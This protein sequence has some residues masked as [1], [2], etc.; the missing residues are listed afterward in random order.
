LVGADPVSSCEQ[1]AMQMPPVS[2]RRVVRCKSASAADVQFHSRW[3]LRNCRHERVPV[4]SCSE[5]TASKWSHKLAALRL[6]SEGDAGELMCKRH[7]RKSCSV[8]P[9]CTSSAPLSSFHT[10][11]HCIACCSCSPFDRR[12]GNCPAFT[13]PVGGTVAVRRALSLDSW[14]AVCHSQQLSVEG[15]DSICA[16]GEVDLLGNYSVTF[17]AVIIH[18]SSSVPACCSSQMRYYAAGISFD[19]L[20]D[21]TN[22]QTPN[23]GLNLASSD[24]SAISADAKSLSSSSSAAETSMSPAVNYM[25]NQ[26]S[27]EEYRSRFEVCAFAAVSR[28]MLIC[29]IISMLLILY[30]YCHS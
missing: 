6:S 21:D 3:H 27:P 28:C 11:C 5:N 30:Y 26:V 24:Q 4:S 25:N 15:K 2:V 16:N 7:Q 20:N 29:I 19:S 17:D 13:F 1:P 18:K 8:A 12:T 14:R 10:E 9:C 22:H 23:P